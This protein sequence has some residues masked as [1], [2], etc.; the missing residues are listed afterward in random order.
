[1]AKRKKS[2]P[3][4]EKT[5]ASHREAIDALDD[6]II[7]LLSKRSTIVE[8]VGQLKH[9]MAR[10]D[11]FIRP[12]R[13][14]EIVR[15]IIRNT[16]SHLSRPAMGLIWRLIIASSIN[17]EETVSIASLS[18]PESDECYWVAREHFGA[19]TSNQRLPTC[20][21]ILREVVSKQVTVGVLPLFDRV[22]MPSWWCR[23]VEEK[24]QPYV[25]ARLPFVRLA[26]SAKPPIVAIG[27]V[28]PE[29]TRHDTS[30][31]VIKM[32]EAQP[33]ETALLALRKTKIEF[34]VLEHCRVIANP[35]LRYHLISVSGFLDN[36]SVE[37]QRFRQ[38]ANAAN[39][40]STKVQVFFLGAYA[41]PIDIN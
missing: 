8:K 31:W 37:M 11:S 12:G 40:M 27:H 25:F 21:E 26:P 33:F 6:R 34:E 3:R 28:T 35:T 38:K 19:F 36:Q 23:A 30:L 24:K 2:S 29:R 22:S 13:E 18:S 10:D 5:L 39:T 16:E 7:T 4:L 1:M 41:N 32:D 9:K 15:R 17:I 14:A 20:A